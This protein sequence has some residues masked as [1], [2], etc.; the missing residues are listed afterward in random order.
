MDAFRPGLSGKRPHI[1][2]HRVKGPDIKQTI[3]KSKLKGF[4]LASG[5]GRFQ[6]RH[7]MM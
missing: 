4:W 1:H 2:L 3:V 5:F 7:L 6:D